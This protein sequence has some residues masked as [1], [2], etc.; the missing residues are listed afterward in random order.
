M[1]CVCV[2]SVGASGDIRAAA[3]DGDVCACG[4]KWAGG[5]EGGCG[6]TTH[7][8]GSLRKYTPVQGKARGTHAARLTFLLNVCMMEQF[9]EK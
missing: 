3:C 8:R 2:D 5:L 1:G 4:P 7:E 6:T 9:K